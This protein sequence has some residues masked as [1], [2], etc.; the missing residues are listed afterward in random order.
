MADFQHE[1]TAVITIST[2]NAA[3]TLT[4]ATTTQVKVRDADGTQ[5]LAAIL[6]PPNELAYV[7]FGL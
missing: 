4:G 7:R 3:G 1:E 2:T 5:L 6:C